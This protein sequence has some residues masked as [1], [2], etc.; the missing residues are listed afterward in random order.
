MPDTALQQQ[1]VISNVFLMCF[2]CVSM[3][4]G[5]VPWEYS[6]RSSSRKR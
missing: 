2:L 1:A 6:S 5:Q 3:F 4:Q